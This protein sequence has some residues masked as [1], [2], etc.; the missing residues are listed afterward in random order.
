MEE[1]KTNRSHKDSVFTRLFSEKNNLLELYGAIS[2]KSYPENTKIE[3]VTLSD[4]LYMNQLNDIA[5]VLDGRL[6]VLV[7][8]QSTINNNMPLRMLMYLASEYQLITD[9]KNLYK[10]S[11]VKIPAPE[12]IVLYNGDKKFPDYKELKLSDSYSFKTSECYLELMVKV[13]NI[14]KGCNAA[15]A[16]KSPVL[17]GYE[18]FIAG[19]KENLKCMEL[20]EAVKLAIKTCMSKNIL[21]SF[22]ER[23]GSEVENMLLTEWNQDDALAVRYEEGREEGI[24]IGL[25]RGR[26]EGREEL[27]ALWEKGISLAEAKELL[28]G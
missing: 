9:R 20:R 17:S 22:L 5:F 19:I 12:F 28:R 24:G 25:N 14:N 4:V 10:Q 18:E 7:E 11:R 6:I 15:I 26:E 3:I 23:N 27:F 13:Y 8:H 21:L 2:G 1:M 16:S